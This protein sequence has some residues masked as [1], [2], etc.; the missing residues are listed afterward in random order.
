VS[1]QLQPLLSFVFY[2]KASLIIVV[3]DTILEC[4]S[5]CIMSPCMDASTTPSSLETSV[6]TLLTPPQLTSLKA[7]HWIE[8]LHFLPDFTEHPKPKR[9]PSLRP[10][11]SLVWSKSNDNNNNSN[12]NNQDDD[13]DDQQDEVSFW[14]DFVAGGMAGSASVMVGHPFD[15]IKVRMQTSTQASMRSELASFSTL[16]RGM[17][18]PLSAA[19]AINAIVFSS[20]G[21]ASRFYDAYNVNALMSSLSFSKSNTNNN[22]IS[23]NDYSEDDINVTHDPWQKASVCGSFAGFMQCFII[24]PME[25]VKCRLQIQSAKSL[26]AAASGTLPQPAASYYTGPVQATHDII[27]QHGFSRLFQGWTATLWREIPAFGMYFA[28]YDYL[29]DRANTFLAHHA[30]GDVDHLPSWSTT[31]RLPLHSHTWLASMFAGGCAGSVTW[32]VV[33]PVDVLKTRIQT[34]PLNTPRSEL[35]MTYLARHIIQQHGWRYLF[36]GLGITLIRAFP[37]NGTIFPVYEFTLMHVTN[38]SSSNNK[39]N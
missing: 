39:Y 8:P 16:F 3:V 34:A 38:Y 35:R 26:S 6:S 24:C 2:K 21:A 30:Q 10:T 28:V 23:I 19:T 9:H 33:Y 27:R 36:R 37:V 13:D 32:A 12:G 20:Y 14:H 11:E 31:G 7:L 15:T 17:A 4:L 29:K 22:N 5:V 25:H 18:A 1:Q